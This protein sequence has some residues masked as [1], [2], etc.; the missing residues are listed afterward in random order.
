M[1][2]L[3]ECMKSGCTWKGTLQKYEEEVKQSNGTTFVL[4]EADYYHVA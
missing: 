2:E 4:T 3:V 1:N